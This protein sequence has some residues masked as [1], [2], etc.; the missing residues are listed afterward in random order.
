M[1]WLLPTMVGKS[2]A[3]ANCPSG[4][5]PSS[6]TRCNTVWFKS[7][8]RQ[9]EQREVPASIERPF[10]PRSNGWGSSAPSAGVPS[11][12]KRE[13]REGARPRPGTLLVLNSP[14][15]LI[16]IVQDVNRASETPDNALAL[17]R[18]GLAADGEVLTS[19]SELSRCAIL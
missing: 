4:Q 5:Y 1:P 19:M 9:G 10:C 6:W 11:R 17:Q 12:R 7:S 16:R 13:A 8:A 15:R 14:V 18:L 3:P 2:S